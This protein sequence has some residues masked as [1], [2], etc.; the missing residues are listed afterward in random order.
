MITFSLIRITNYEQLIDHTEIALKMR[1]KQRD[2]E[3]IWRHGS[4]LS[5]IKSIVIMHR[6]HYFFK[7]NYLLILV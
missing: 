3:A 1:K 7:K 5:S 4:F 6:L 2:R